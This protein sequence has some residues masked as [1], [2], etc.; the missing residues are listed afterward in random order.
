MSYDGSS[1]A[2]VKGRK[3]T[4]K[5][6]FKRNFWKNKLLQRKKLLNFRHVAKKYKKFRE[7]NIFYVHCMKKL[8]NDKTRIEMANSRN[9]LLLSGPPISSTLY[10]IMWIRQAQ[11]YIKLTK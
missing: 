4:L 8:A 9:F 11:E 7:K 6:Y 2:F 10:L 3:Y 1:V 5:V